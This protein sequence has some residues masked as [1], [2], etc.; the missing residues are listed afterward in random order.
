MKIIDNRGKVAR[1][2]P[3]RTYGI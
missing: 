2:S 1:T 3:S